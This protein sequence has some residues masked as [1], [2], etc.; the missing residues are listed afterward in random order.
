MSAWD[1][2]TPERG[3]SR[4]RRSLEDIEQQ[5]TGRFPELTADLTFGELTFFV[6]PDQLVEVLRYCRDDT[7]LACEMLADLGGV[8]WPSGDHVVQRQSSTT[9]W[10]EYRISRDEGV[11]EVSYVLRSVSRNH[12]FRVSVATPD[13]APRL[14]SV[15]AIYPTANYHERE[16]YDFFGVEFDGHP[17]LTRIL[18]PDDWLGHPHRKDYPLGGVTIDYKHD[19]FI[20][21]P[22]ERDLREVV[23]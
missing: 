5:V 22:H 9:G 6:A 17:G 15:T 11:I 2:P 23:E 20:P 19:K 18:M 14:P 13:D 12:R 8:H 1:V 3:V 10:P 7:E 21:P 16:V 4:E